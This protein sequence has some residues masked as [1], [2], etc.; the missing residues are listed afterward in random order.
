MTSSQYDKEV[1]NLI[2]PYVYDWTA[3]Q[4]GSIIAEHGLG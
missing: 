3:N 1:M 2:E 4:K